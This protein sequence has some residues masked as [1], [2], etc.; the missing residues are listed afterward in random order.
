MGTV[1][2]NQQQVRR[3]QA[4]CALSDHITAERRQ[5]NAGDARN[6]EAIECL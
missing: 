5:R 1:R 3:Y 4:A 2:G 6:A